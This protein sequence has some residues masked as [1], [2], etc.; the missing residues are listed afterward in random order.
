MRRAVFLDR[1]GTIS[2]EAGYINHI[3]RFHLYPWAAGAVK[4]LNDA[5]WLVI[6]ATNQ[7]GIARGYFPEALMH[8]IHNDVQTELASRGAHLDAIYYCPHLAAGTVPEYSKPCECR[9]PKI[10]MLLKAAED[11]Q[12]DL[13]SCFVIGD[14]YVDIET[15]HH[16]GAQG[17]LVLSGYGKGEH[18]YLAHTWPRQPAQIAQ[19]VSAAA[20][21][22]LQN[23]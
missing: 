14:R 10:G 2:E 7:S 1:D 5:G 22:I 18:L 19:D 17:V 6:L 13:P 12:L 21:W 23:S 9:K 8:Q 16:A 4:K 20:D 3:D 11:F 15:A